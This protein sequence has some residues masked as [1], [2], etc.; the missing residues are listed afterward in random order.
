MKVVRPTTAILVT[1]LA[2]LPLFTATAE[3]EAVATWGVTIDGS[4]DFSYAGHLDEND[5]AYALT[6][7]LWSRS[8][9]P[10]GEDRSIEL[11]AQGS[12][13][14][15]DD[16]D[17]LVD[18]DLLRARGRFPGLFGPDSVVRATAGRFR[19]R[20][21]TGIVLNHVLD[22]M[23]TRVNY[24]GVRTRFAAAYTGLQLNPVSDIRMT[25]ADLADSGDDDEFF[26]PRRIVGVAEVSFPEAFLRQT[27]TAG[28]TGQFDLRDADD[29]EVTFNSGYFSLAAAGPVAGNLY[30]DLSGTAMV[31]RS[32]LD[33]DTDDHVGFL[34]NGR[35]RYFRE[36]RLSSR[37]GAGVTWASGTGDDVD[38]FIPISRSTAGT[39]VSVP[40]ENLIRTDLS[41]SF[42]PSEKIQVGYNV[43]WFFTG[44]EDDLPQ[45]ALVDPDA[46]GRWI[47][48]EVVARV[49]ARLTSDLG[50]A[51]TGGIF[52]PS[53][54]ENGIYDDAREAEHLL[55][56]ELS[57]G[58]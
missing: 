19:F 17:Y 41:Y 18:V 54:G 16:R 32:D 14:W 52:A 38:R 8:L 7:A 31:G 30:H 10:L 33:G 55:R 37:I 13:T 44:H 27:V 12:Y 49:S 23:Q 43:G 6:T 1:A 3:S 20:D 46:D 29:E 15:S 48:T 22:G 26:G 11:T 9:F 57:T 47:G 4:A 58:F 25:P 50:L 28:V 39:I 36:D 35:L 24:P 2:L 40:V 21:T 53:S 34:L 51:V 45:S 56:V 5:P 42:R